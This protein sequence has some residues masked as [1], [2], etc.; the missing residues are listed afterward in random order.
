[1]EILQTREATLRRIMDGACNGTNAEAQAQQSVSF[2][3][4][5]FVHIQ[6]NKTFRMQC[7]FRS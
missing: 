1:M 7:R 4:N 6:G 5:S 2:K 3:T